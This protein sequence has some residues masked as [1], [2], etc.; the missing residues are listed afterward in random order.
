MNSD[1]V[2]VDKADEHLH[3]S[4]GRP[5]CVAVG[6]RE[7]YVLILGFQEVFGFLMS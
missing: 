4:V 1:A 3:G 2:K 5:C 7:R 6:C